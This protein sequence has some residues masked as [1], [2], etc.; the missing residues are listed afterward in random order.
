[1]KHSYIETE[2]EGDESG[3]SAQ[4]SIYEVSFGYHPDLEGYTTLMSD[5]LELGVMFRRNIK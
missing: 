3:Q 1:M 2:V 5:I 4:G